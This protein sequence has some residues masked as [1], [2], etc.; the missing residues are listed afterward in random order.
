MKHPLI[1]VH[2]NQL[3]VP[4]YQS[5]KFL[6]R[7]SA[8]KAISQFALLL[9]TLLLLQ[10]SLAVSL[11]VAET[12]I[13][14]V[15]GN[16]GYVSGKLQNPVNDARSIASSLDKL[17][18]KV[19]LR[20]NLDRKHMH[21]ALNEFG[22]QLKKD[23]VGLFYYAGHG[24]Q[25]NGKNF[26]IP[27]DADIR[28]EDDIE[29]SGIDANMVLSQM[30][31]AQDRV[32]LLILDACRNNPF[33]RNTRA[34]SLGLA[35]M[36]AP[37]GTLI[38]F[39]TA[40][41]S[42][43]FDGKEGNSIYTRNLVQKLA[44]PDLAVEA[45][46]K[47]V[48]IAVTKETNEKQV[49]WE[50]SSLMGDFYFVPQVPTSHIVSPPPVLTATDTGSTITKRSEE[51]NIPNEPIS[52]PSSPQKP[53]VLIEKA[54]RDFNQEGYEIEIR[55][56]TLTSDELPSL[57]A[58]AKQGDVVA[59]TTLGWAYLLGKGQMDGRDIPRSN[60]KMFHWTKAAAD[61]GYPVAEN[62]LGM[63]Y[64]NGVGA[65]KDLVLAS[66]YLKRAADQGYISAQSNLILVNAMLTGK[67]DFSAFQDLVNNIQKEMHIPSQ[68]DSK[69]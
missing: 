29:F 3:S 22:K 24:M 45:L 14:L 58:H 25:I 38:A 5:Q 20:E 8:T 35:Q 68:H 60:K 59:Q 11:P 57:E 9:S 37:K 13:A 4:R 64:M 65:Q 23:G 56:K 49:P 34:V 69:H 61:H 10:S 67:P 41:G 15:I 44:S 54:H 63:I 28:Q 33:S 51:T 18:F 6:S 39:S 48:R 26:L 30:E 7:L 40:P 17:G 19:M 21:Q 53:S 46:F 31:A 42:L 43:A 32:N 52:K 1:D 50:S 66:R 12:R 2:A 16:A 47:E 36:N 55:A 27:V 62:N